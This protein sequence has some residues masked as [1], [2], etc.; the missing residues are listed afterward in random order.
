MCLL[1]LLQWAGASHCWWFSF[2]L[3]RGFRRAGSVVVAHGAQL[4]WGMW[5]LPRP[6]ITPV[7]PELAGRLQSLNHQVSPD[8][9]RVSAVQLFATP[10]TVAHQAPLPMEFSKQEYRSGVPFSSSGD[11]PDPRLNPGLLH[12]R[13]IFYCLSHQGSS[14]INF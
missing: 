4:L 14:H 2:L 11:L 6:G 1:S 5:D 8:C 7:C 12:C 10:W 3:S 13:Q 9:T